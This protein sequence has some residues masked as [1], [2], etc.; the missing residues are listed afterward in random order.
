MPNFEKKVV[1]GNGFIWIVWETS[2]L[3]GFPLMI[4]PDVDF[5]LLLLHHLN[6]GVDTLENPALNFT[7]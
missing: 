2:C 6:V 5:D 3:L 1:W 4:D 7:F